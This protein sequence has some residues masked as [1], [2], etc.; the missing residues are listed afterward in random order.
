M[1]MS[2]SEHIATWS[3]SAARPSNLYRYW[4]GVICYMLSPMSSLEFEVQIRRE[5]LMID[6]DMQKPTHFWLDDRTN[7]PRPCMHNGN[8][9]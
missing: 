7:H 3:L 9:E 8:I 1:S 4:R 2:M 5:D 6:V